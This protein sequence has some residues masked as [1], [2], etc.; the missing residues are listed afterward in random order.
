MGE[1]QAEG[2]R[3]APCAPKGFLRHHIIFLVIEPI[4]K[5][6]KY[7]YARIFARRGTQKPGFPL[8]FLRS[9]DALL[10][11]FPL[12]SLAPLRANS[13]FASQNRNQPLGPTGWL[14][15]ALTAHSHSLRVFIILKPPLYSSFFS[16]SLTRPFR[17]IKAPRL[18]RTFFPRR[19]ALRGE[20]LQLATSLN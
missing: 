5:S 11:G 2:L 17:L 6:K 3:P 13:D 7:L 9:A 15:A 14:F 1:Q 8:Q 20:D 16:F 19:Q 12:Q 18:K 4:S 10:A